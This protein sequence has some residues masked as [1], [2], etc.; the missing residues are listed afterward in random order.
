MTTPN[1]SAPWL[2]S[3]SAGVNP[4]IEVPNE[5][6]T[7]A[8]SRSVA[9]FGARVA[10]DFMGTAITYSQL[11]QRVDLAAGMLQGIGVKH[12]DR[13]AIA[14]P[15]SINHVVV[16]YAILRLGAIVVEHN[17]LYTQAELI[18]QLNDSGATVAVFWDKTAQTLGDGLNQTEV[19]TLISVDVSKELPVVKKILLQLPVAKARETKAALCATPP[20]AALRWHELMAKATPLDPQTPRARSEDIAV[21]QYTGGTTGTPK[22]AM[23]THRNLAA[24]AVQGAEWTGADESPGTEVVYGVLPFFHAFGLTLCLTYALRIAATVVLFPKFEVESFLAAQKKHPGT[25]LP[26]VPPMLARLAAASKSKG[27][28]LSSFKYAI[29][30]AM[31][32]PRA[33]ADAWEAATGGLVIEGYGMTETSPVALGNPLSAARIPGRL[34]LPFPSTDAMIVDESDGF[35]RLAQGE[36]GELLLSGPQVFSGYW[37][38]PEE[39]A[40]ILVEIDGKVW[41]RTGDV[42]VMDETGSFTLVDRIKEM[43]ITGGFKVFPSQVEACLRGMP[44]VADAAVV[45][46]PTSSD[47]GESVVAALVLEEGASGPSLKEVQE[48]CGKELA[49]YALPRDLVIVPELPVSQIGKVMRRVVRDQILAAQ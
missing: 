6:V 28:D 46:L 4:T 20:A 10:L 35:T 40:N 11:G 17:P 27:A 26:A 13:V 43:I 39:T 34:G 33:T 37:G 16:F 32:L 38:R 7:S 22:G 9:N 24:N 3:Y 41:I 23:L 18:H 25:F 36:R 2:A 30:G 45:G 12:G 31:P 14:M 49:R 8:F 1:V 19:K 21:L 47:L 15:N 29:S 44:G 5:D 42:C 48:W